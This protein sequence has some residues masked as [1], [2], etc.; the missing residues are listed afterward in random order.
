MSSTPGSGPLISWLVLPLTAALGPVAAYNLLC[1]LCPALAA[2][3]A[4]LLCRHLAGNF[5]AA[6]LGGYLFGFS[7]YV[8]GHILCGHVDC[9]SV[10]LIP[11]VAYLALAR[12]EARLTRLAFGLWL[13]ALLVAQFLI[14]DEFFV[15]MTLV[16]AVA[17]ALAWVCGQRDRKRRIEALAAPI[18][19]A[20]LG[21][22]RKAAVLVRNFNSSVGRMDRGHEVGKRARQAGAALILAARRG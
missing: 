9:F 20:Y 12:L 16:G 13:F 1:V 8:L 4:F 10:F 2:W 11:L 3:S 15:T 5:R 22:E 17:L 21:T 14:V 18:S 19:L 7:T 6:L